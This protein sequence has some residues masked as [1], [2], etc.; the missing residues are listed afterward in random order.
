MRKYCAWMLALVLV[1]SMTACA[2]AEGENDVYGLLSGLMNGHSFTLTVTAEEAEGLEE[3][4]APY[5]SFL[6]TLQQ[7]EDTIVLDVTTE[8]EAFLKATATAEGV[9]I[10]TNFVEMEDV[11][12]TWQTLVPN[13]T[14]TREEGVVSLKIGM[15]GPDKEL[16]N[17]T[18]KAK[19]TDLSDYSADVYVGFIT[20]PGAIYSL[21]DSF[22][23]E[24]GSS[25]RDFAFTF[26]EYEV[27]VYGEGEELTE[28]AE[29]GSV[30]IVRTDAYTVEY[31]AE[32]IGTLTIHAELTIR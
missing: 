28:E 21:W 4:L 17:F 27:M 8:G 31:D 29:D 24:E 9:T 18:F 2:F 7:E 16:I 30:T 6:C 1:V 23:A 22:G 13:V 11:S 10:S 14:L 3:F 26:D 32:E 12:V 5:G 19:G 25:V 20:G 15:T